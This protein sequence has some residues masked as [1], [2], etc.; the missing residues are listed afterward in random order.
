MNDLANLSI[1]FIIWILRLALVG[2]IYLFIWRIMRIMMRGDQHGSAVGSLGAYL[3]VLDPGRTKLQR[4][5]AHMLE[6][7]STLG[8]KADNLIV[9][10]DLLVSEHHAIIQLVDDQ[11]II[12]DLG[13][14]NK[15]YI[16]NLQIVSAVTLSHNDIISI[17][18]LKFR[19][20]I[21]STED[22]KRI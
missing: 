18:P 16:N 19:M 10:D 3:V 12:R 1:E 22:K 8:R 5:H 2:M 20:F 9:I 7:N 11:W 15:T 6:V 21:Q 4:G 13:S 17:G 14:T